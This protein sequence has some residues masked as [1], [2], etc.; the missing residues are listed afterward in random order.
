V[1]VVALA[2]TETED[3][4]LAYAEAGVTG[5]VPRHGTL[6]TLENTLADSALAL[7]LGTPAELGKSSRLFININRAPLDL[8]LAQRGAARGRFDYRASDV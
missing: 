8:D 7:L 1:R 4:I 2:V 6:E 3:E 5:F